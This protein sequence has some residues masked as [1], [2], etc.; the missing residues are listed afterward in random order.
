M[1]RDQSVIAAGGYVVQLMPG[2]PDDVLEK[3]EKNVIDAGAATA[4]LIE[5]GRCV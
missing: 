1:D 3:L 2:A 4:M 5:G